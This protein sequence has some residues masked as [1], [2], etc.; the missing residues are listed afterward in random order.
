MRYPILNVEE[1]EPR[2]SAGALKRLR[3]EGK[4]PAVLS[5]AG[6]E[7]VPLTLGRDELAAAVHKTGVGGIMALRDASGDGERLGMLKELQWH[8]VS[9]QI[10]HAA[11]QEVRQDQVVTTRVPVALVGEPES[12]ADKTGQ[13]IRSSESIELHARVLSL[14]DKVAVDVSG[15]ELGDVLTAGDLQLPEGCECVQPSA[16]LCSVTTPTVHEIEEPEAAE[17]LELEGEVAAE[18]EEA[19]EEGDEK[20]EG[21]APE[22]GDKAGE[23]SRDGAGKRS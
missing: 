18:G 11:F 12:V 4:L 5:R 1:R 14:P 10:L 2:V 19:A 22:A 16:V 15:L 8:P 21:E 3:R 7:P 9:K 6:R 20:K 17:E 13:L 23:K